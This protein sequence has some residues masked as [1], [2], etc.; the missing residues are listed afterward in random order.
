MTIRSQ[1][2]DLHVRIE[3]DRFKNAIYNVRKFTFLDSFYIE[4][5]PIG[6][7]FDRNVSKPYFW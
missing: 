2:S 6:Q 5:S 1:F 3:I 7:T 4:A